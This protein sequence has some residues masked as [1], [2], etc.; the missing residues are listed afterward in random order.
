[1]AYEAHYCMWEVYF[2]RPTITAVDASK[3]F[4]RLDHTI[5]L[6]KLISRKL[7][8]CFIKI[9]SCWYSKLYSSVRWNSYI[10]A[11]FQESVKVEFCRL[12]CLI[13]MLMTLLKLWR[14]MAMV[15]TFVT[16]TLVVLCMPT[17]S[18]QRVTFYDPRPTWP[19]SQSTRDP[20]DPWPVTHDYSPHQSLSQCDV[21]V[22]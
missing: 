6:D 7:P 8:A 4:D 5:L 19:I 20:R 3:A 9:I 15:V 16:V 18:W 10:G 11:Q 1:M 12:F 17:Q 22:P 2:P 21:C 13:C 14:R